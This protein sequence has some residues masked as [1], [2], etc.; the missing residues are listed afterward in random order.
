MSALS[1]KFTDE[2]LLILLEAA[3]ITLS[4][5]DTYDM[6]VDLMD[7]DDDIMKALQEKLAAV[8]NKE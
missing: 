4:D 5:G 6:C 2:E 7:I 1:D 3:R 8:L